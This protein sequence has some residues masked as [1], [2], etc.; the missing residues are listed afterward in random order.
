MTEITAT[1][2]QTPI[3]YPIITSIDNRYNVLKLSIN[4]VYKLGVE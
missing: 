3:E 1:I 2:P 4:M